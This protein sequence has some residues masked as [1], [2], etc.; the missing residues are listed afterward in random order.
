M[1]AHKRS[2]KAGDVVLKTILSWLNSALATKDVGAAMTS[3]KVS[4]N[5][6]QATDGKLTASHPW[7]YKGEFLVPGQEFEK[8]LKRMGDDPTLSVQDNSIKLKSGRFS[9]TIQTIPLQEWNHAGI[10]GVKWCPIPPTLIPIL[11][12]LRP[13]V[14]EN[15]AQAWATCVALDSGWCMATNNIAIAGA[16]CDGLGDVKALL[17]AWT[18]DFLLGR[19]DGLT[20]WGWEENFVAFRW[21]SGAWM[22]SQLIVGQFPE[23]AADMVKASIKEK[24]TQKISDEMRSA[25][26]TVAELAE[27]TLLVYADCIRSRFGKAIVEEGV[28]S[29]VPKGEKASI[30]GAKFLWPAIQAADVWS[31]AAWPKPAPFKGELISGWV[32]GRKT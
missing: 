6:I 27:D 9:G 5:A 25:F 11:K 17:P 8:V 30:W 31:P 23:K 24:P 2:N 32:V 29:E 14:S 16:K 1:Q 10:D 20:E 12:A 7:P 22:R 3:Y 18:I 26:Q 28:E 21:A 13:F 15:N 4:Q 19:A